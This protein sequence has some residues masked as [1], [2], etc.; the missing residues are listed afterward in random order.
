[1]GLDIVEYVMA[2]EDAFEVAL[3]HNRLET[4]RT[5]R[6]FAALVAEF[7]PAADSGPCLSQRAFYRLRWALLNG[8]GLPR[9]AIKSESVL[10]DLL[11]AESPTELWAAICCELQLPKPLGLRGRHGVLAFLGMRPTTFANA[12]GELMMR[13]PRR[14]LRAGE[15]WTASQIHAVLAQL[16]D[17]EQGISPGSYSVDAS[18]VH[19]LGMD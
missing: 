11:P 10:V 3:P 8:T 1:M 12:A 9:R 6:D 4:V 7:I 19:D 5:P 18:Y 14:L 16:L 13:Y 2:V 15:G 17:R